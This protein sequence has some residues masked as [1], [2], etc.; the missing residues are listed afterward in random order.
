MRLTPDVR[1]GMQLSWPVLNQERATCFSLVDTQGL[2]VAVSV[3]GGFGDRVD[4]LL[5]FTAEV[6]GDVG[7]AQDQNLIVNWVSEGASTYGRLAGVFNLSNNGGV[8]QWDDSSGAWSQKNEDLPLTWARTNLTALARGTGGFMLAGLARGST[9][10]ADPTGLYR[11][12]NGRWERVAADLFGVNNLITQIGIS[13]ADNRRFAVGTAAR[14]LYVTSDGGQTF[15]NWTSQLDPRT[16]PPAS[17]RVSALEWTTTR[18][19]VALSQFGVFVSTDSGTAFSVSPFRV[20]SNRDLVNPVAT[21]PVVEDL[22]ADPAAPDRFVA[23]LREHGCYETTDGGLTWHDLYGDL[24]VRG[25][26]G[27][28]VRNAKGVAIV[29]GSPATIVLGLLQDGLYRSVD[30]GL[31]WTKVALEPEVQP[32]AT[33]ALQEFA[34]ANVPGRPG[35]LAVF[36]NEHGLLR[37]EDG[38][39]T[40]AFAASQPVI[41]RAVLLLPGDETGDLVLGTWGGGLYRAGEVLPLSETYT[42]NTDPDLRNLDLGLRLTVG[43]GALQTGS[44][45]RIAA[46]TYQGWAVWRSLAGDPDNMT[47]IGLYDLLNH[48]DCIEG[49]CGDETYNIVPRC[50]AAKRA[51]CF[52][53]STPDTVRF[54]DDEIFNGFGYNYAVSSFDYGNTALVSPENNSA[55]MVFSPRW[56]GDAGS[57]FAGAGNREFVH[58]NESAAAPDTGDEIYAFPNPVR[59]GAGFSGAEGERVAFTNLPPGSRVRLFTTAGDFVN[60]LGPETQ[61]A[62]QIYWATD[63]LEGEQVAAGVYLYRVDMPQRSVYWGRIAV[64][65]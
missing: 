21:V 36:E 59:R 65:R 61:V 6:D 54:F 48:E 9:L 45:F 1:A 49:Y 17:Y 58:I 64:I 2:G 27:A 26:P 60:D 44:T 4:R 39:A 31:H 7:L 8:W 15:V 24:S 28:W 57:P 55:S 23:A 41:D 34:I 29:A 18:L 35:S 42:T 33:V 52:D 40:W 51:A 50:F 22:A 5:R 43:A 37:S 20:P 14:G 38:G 16:T 3:S 53:F 63:N 19:L 13:P 10:Q 62:G 25:A 56:L 46:Q 30:G 47:M 32:E 12:E 11:Y